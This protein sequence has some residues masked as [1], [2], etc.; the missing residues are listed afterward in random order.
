[1]RRFQVQ[2]SEDSPD[3]ELDD[4][5]EE[6]LDKRFNGRN[7]LVVILSPRRP[8]VSVHDDVVDDGEGEVL[9]PNLEYQCHSFPPN[10][11]SRLERRF[12][13]GGDREEEVEDDGESDESRPCGRAVEV[14]RGE[15]ATENHVGEGVN[16]WE[17]NVEHHQL[18]Y[19]E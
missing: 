11:P 12:R 3:T 2:L 14:D 16:R 15:L 5:L 17:D 6:R 10:V 8:T 1:M 18:E 7:V 9:R 13:V 4:H 19:Y